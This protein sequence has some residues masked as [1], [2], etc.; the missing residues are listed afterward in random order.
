MFTEVFN[1][2]TLDQRPALAQQERQRR[3]EATPEAY[4]AIPVLVPKMSSVVEGAVADYELFWLV[5][6]PGPIEHPRFPDKM[7]REAINFQCSREETAEDL[8]FVLNN[9]RLL[10]EISDNAR[11]STVEELNEQVEDERIPEDVL[12]S[13]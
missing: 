4:V 7:A 5:G 13:G 9:G 10:R 6:L 8:V 1:K 3:V 2:A 12:T 11:K